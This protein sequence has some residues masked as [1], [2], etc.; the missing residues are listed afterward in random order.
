M[1]VKQGEQGWLLG[2]AS[3]NHEFA[4]CFY[5]D[6]GKGK[7]PRYIVGQGGASRLGV[8]ELVGVDVDPDGATF[9][10]ACGRQSHLPRSWFQLTWR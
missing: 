1:L 6:D 5:W 3:G 7:G 9:S 2:G 10:W 8:S 4:R